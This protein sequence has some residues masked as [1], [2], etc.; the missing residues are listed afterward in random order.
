MSDKHFIHNH[1]KLTKYYYFD[2]VI[3]GRIKMKY[4]RSRSIEKIILDFVELIYYENIFL[5][6]YNI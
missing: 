2:I 1:Y 5:R 6:E 3:V 4:L